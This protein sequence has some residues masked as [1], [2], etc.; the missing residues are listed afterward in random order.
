M[1]TVFI[2]V[3]KNE[4]VD[5]DVINNF[6]EDIRSKYVSKAGINNT[7]FIVASGNASDIFT[8]LDTDNKKRPSF[9][10]SRLYDFYG[11]LPSATWDWLKEKIPEIKMDKDKDKNK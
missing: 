6:L 8:K 3:Y 4:G 11:T 1:E 2:I 9:F 5:K 10:I 7:I